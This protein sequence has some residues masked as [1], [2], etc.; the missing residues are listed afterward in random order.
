MVFRDMGRVK[1]REYLYFLLNVLDLVLRTLEVNDL[2]SNSLL[3]SFIVSESRGV[4]VEVSC[5]TRR[6]VRTLYTPLQMIPCLCRWYEDLFSQDRLR[7]NGR[8]CA[9][10]LSCL[11]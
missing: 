10:I 11:T 5:W 2:D 1:L 6:T 3:R 7:H 8:K 9:P 4:K